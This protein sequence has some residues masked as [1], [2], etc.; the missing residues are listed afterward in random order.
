MEVTALLPTLRAMARRYPPQLREDLVQEAFVSLLGLSPVHNPQAELPRRYLLCC[1]RH[2]ML[3]YARR[4]AKHRASLLLEEPT[5][6]DGRLEL[7]LALIAIGGKPNVGR[8]VM[9]MATGKALSGADRV[10]LHRWRKGLTDAD[11]G[12]AVHLPANH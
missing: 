10:A 11:R 2:A 1:A 5:H 7:A 12:T 3:A 6:E 8:A 9:A 4:E